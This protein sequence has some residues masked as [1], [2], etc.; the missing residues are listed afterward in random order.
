MKSKKNPSI[1]FATGKNDKSG[2]Q[3]NRILKQRNGQTERL[4]ISDN[5]A[6]AIIN[7]INKI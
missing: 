2:N 5:N 1:I 7:F 3:I 4:E 6:K